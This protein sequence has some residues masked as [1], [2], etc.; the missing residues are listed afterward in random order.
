MIALAVPA[1]PSIPAAR[2]D[3]GAHPPRTM[4]AN[5]GCTE[6]TSRGGDR[7]GSPLVV[8]LSEMGPEGAAAGSWPGNPAVATDDRCLRL[9][10]PRGRSRSRWLLRTAERQALFSARSTE[11]SDSCTGPITWRLVL[12]LSLW[13]H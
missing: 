11:P 5:P 3:E 4:V 1:L 9:E 10:R 8:S 13:R 6:I 12:P 7:A 2:A